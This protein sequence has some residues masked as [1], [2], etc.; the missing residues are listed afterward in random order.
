MKENASQIIKN[1]KILENRLE[2]AYVRFNEAVSTNQAL[3][4]EIDN[5]R[6]ERVVFDTAR[7]HLS[8]R[9]QALRA[10]AGPAT[11][12]MARAPRGGA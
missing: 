1:V 3:R 9:P 5:L 7:A 12:A 6:R 8:P 11:T 4:E 2:K 10:V